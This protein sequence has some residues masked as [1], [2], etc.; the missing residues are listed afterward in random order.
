LAG[1]IKE[2]KGLQVGWNYEWKR[3]YARDNKDKRLQQ[4]IK[5]QEEDGKKDNIPG[6]PLRD[7]ISKPVSS[8][9]IIYLLAS[10]CPLVSEN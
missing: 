2:I 7:S 4:N 10:C 6:S 1:D 5:L 3:Y 9:I 8:P